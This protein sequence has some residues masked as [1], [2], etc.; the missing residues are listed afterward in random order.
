MKSK[1]SSIIYIFEKARK[2]K[3]TPFGVLNYLKC[4]LKTEQREELMKTQRLS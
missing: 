2:Q 4:S 3:S 1:M